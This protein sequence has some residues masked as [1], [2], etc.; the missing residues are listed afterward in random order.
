MKFLITVILTISV[1]DVFSQGNP[2][3]IDNAIEEA[4]KNN[5][6]IKA[7]N[8]EFESEKQ[9]RK[10]SFDLPKTDVI[11]L[12]GQYNSYA[13]ND[14]NITISQSIPFS[15]FGSQGS[16]NQAL[17]TSGEIKKSATVNDIVYQVKQ[18]YYQLAFKLAH[19][20]LL[21]RQDSI[22]EGF[23]KSASLRY[24][25]GETN[26]LEQTTAE[27]QRNEAKNQLRQSDGEIAQ[28]QSQLKIIVNSRSL[29]DVA[30][31]DLIAL[32]LENVLDTMGYK[33]N[34]SLTYM[35]QQIEVAESQKKLQSAKFA[36][37]LLVGFFSHTLIGGPTSE[38]GGIATS[39]DRFTGFQLGISLPLWFVPH[40]AK[41]RSAE[42]N[43]RATESRFNHYQASL[44]GLVQRAIQQLNTN[45]NSLDYY[46]TS[47]LPN[48]YL[49]LKQS[50]AA[51]REGE[52]GYAEYLLGVR[53]AINIQERHLKTLNDYN[54]SVIYIEYLTGNK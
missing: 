7:A 28:L 9:L 12:Y 51:Y 15:A 33:T 10:A 41:I 23:L 19:H 35:R 13:K 37:D 47:A 54:Q 27:A 31:T 1:G 32:P 49:I 2:L 46:T 18:T 44:Q 34:P 8:F 11:F 14:N 26:L 17:A 52:I 53:N 39:S 36:P 16:L 45:K 22:Y 6:S 4:L 3:S 40:H 24:K 29:P 48:S 25:T 50:Q 38:T 5:E 42:F 43:M 21:E 20:K 30:A